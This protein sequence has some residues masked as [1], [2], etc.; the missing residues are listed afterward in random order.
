VQ[1]R[2][3]HETGPTAAT[4]EFLN[5]LEDSEPD[6]RDALPL[7]ASVRVYLTGAYESRSALKGRDPKYC[8]LILSSGGVTGNLLIKLMF[9]LCSILFLVIAFEY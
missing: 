7:C 1:C 2:Q 4:I 9:K 6:I 5:E 8:I 3:L